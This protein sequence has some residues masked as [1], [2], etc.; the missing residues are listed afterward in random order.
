VLQLRPP[1]SRGGVSAG[2]GGNSGALVVEDVDGDGDAHGAGVGGWPAAPPGGLLGLGDGDG[3]EEGLSEHESRY[4]HRRYGGP[5]R[6][7]RL[8]GV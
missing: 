1:A 2:G 7:H 4:V 6:D 8:T 3:L 5:S